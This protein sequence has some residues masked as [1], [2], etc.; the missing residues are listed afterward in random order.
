MPT[1]YETG[2]QLNLSHGKP[3]FNMVTYS[4]K[5]RAFLYSWFAET[6]V[7]N[8]AWIKLVTVHLWPPKIKTKT[9]YHK[10]S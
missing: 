1:M 8:V 2:L 5:D 9:F 7:Q 3:H 4:R 6:E 10:K